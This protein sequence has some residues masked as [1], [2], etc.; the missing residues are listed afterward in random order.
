MSRQGLY[1]PKFWSTHIRHLVCIDLLARDQ[2]DQK[3]QYFAQSYK[4]AFV[5]PNF[6]VLGQKSYYLRDEAKVLVP[7]KRKTILAPHFHCF[8]LG[9]GQ[10]GPKC[11]YFAKNAKFWPDYTLFRPKSILIG[12]GVKILVPSLQGTNETLL[13]C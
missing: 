11:Q 3:C 10:N 8:L 7:T 13:S 12:E 2:I 4:N 6:A 1:V 5:G 9:M